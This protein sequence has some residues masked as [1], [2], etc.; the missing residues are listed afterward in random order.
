MFIKIHYNNKQHRSCKLKINYLFL[1]FLKEHLLIDQM[2]Y[3]KY[4]IF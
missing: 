1:I 4:N 2:E 3:S